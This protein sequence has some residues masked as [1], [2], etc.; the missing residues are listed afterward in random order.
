MHASFRTCKKGFIKSVVIY[1]EGLFCYLHLAHFYN[2]I[3]WN[4]TWLYTYSI[5]AVYTHTKSLKYGLLFWR[6]Q[7]SLQIVCSIKVPRVKCFPIAYTCDEKRFSRDLEFQNIKISL[8]VL[9][10][11][12]IKQG[13]LPI[14]VLWNFC[15]CHYSCRAVDC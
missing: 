7:F 12:S 5:Y 15:V 1:V 10:E 8:Y 3:P 9:L 2:C 11:G 14:K 4:S 6:I 13:P